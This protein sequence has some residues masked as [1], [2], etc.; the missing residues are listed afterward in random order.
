MPLP[1]DERQHLANVSV[2]GGSGVGNSEFIVTPLL[3]TLQNP[4]NASLNTVDISLPVVLNGIN[5][6]L[7]VKR[8]RFLQKCHAHCCLRN[9]I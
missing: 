1:V 3:T 8:H 4:S 2:T 9:S 6:V 7:N 5:I